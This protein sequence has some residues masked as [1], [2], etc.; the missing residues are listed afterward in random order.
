MRKI[1]ASVLALILSI[2]LVSCASEEAVQPEQSTTSSETAQSSETTEATP[3]PSGDSDRVLKIGH[4][5]DPANS[6][7]AI[8][9]GTTELFAELSEQTGI[10][11]EIE[12]IPWDQIE[13]KLV[14]TNQAGDPSADIYVISSQ[15][16]ASIVNSGSL[17]PLD[18][19]IDKD[20]DRSNFV[21]GAFEVGTYSGDGKVYCML[22]SIHNRGLWYNKALMPNPP[23][24]R[25][26]LVEFAKAATDKEN[27]IYGFGFWGNQHY[28]SMEVGVGQLMWDAGVKLCDDAG[29]A[30]WATPEAAET[31]KFLADCIHE[32]EISPQTCYTMVDYAEVADMFLAGNI[33][34][35]IS[36]T[37][38]MAKIQTS[39]IFKEGNVGFAPI[40]GTDGPAPTFS[41]GWA[42]A[43]PSKSK[44]PD[45]A[46]EFVVAFSQPEVQTK[47]AK[48]EGGMPIRVESYD[49][50]VFSSGLYKELYA[51]MENGRSMDPFVFYQESLE[52]I[53]MANTTYIMD[54]TAD[55]EQLHLDA[56]NDFNSRYYE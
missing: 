55:I 42:F 54:P 14:M 4:Y 5:V 25:A 8:M 6:E 46:W 27:N 30:T 13:G 37:Y 26:E 12:T 48:F 36:G 53:A 11:I 49:D 18:D 41:N 3:E 34:S 28:A 45:L 39:D 50:E 1:A 47:H 43:I 44:Q 31:V 9:K 56:Q 35:Y 51:N 19:Y 20:L 10:T 22:S 2:S 23:Q 21:P 38:D 52:A 32:Y 7:D 33:A 15:K 29:K 16:L 24:N 40:P 17:L